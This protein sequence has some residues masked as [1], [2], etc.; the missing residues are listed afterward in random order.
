VGDGRVEEQ[1]IAR[2]QLVPAHARQ[3]GVLR[4]R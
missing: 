3:H 4:G 1:Q 2:L